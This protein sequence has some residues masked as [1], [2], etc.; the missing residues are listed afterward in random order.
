MKGA[1]CCI[2]LLFIIALYSSVMTL[3]S[4]SE[5]PSTANGGGSEILYHF[6]VFLPDNNYTFYKELKLGAQEAGREL[7]CALSFHP[8]GEEKLDF[9]MAQYSRFDGMIVYPYLEDHL[10]RKILNEINRSDVPIILVEHD[11]QDDS[12]WP[13]V[14]TNNF[15]VGRKIGELI[16]LYHKAPVEMAVVYSNKSPG[17]YA[18][19]ELVE[20]GIIAHLGDRLGAPITSRRTNLNPL[21]A[22][23]LMYH[24][25]RDEPNINTV[26]FTDSN[27]T[28]AATQV[29]ID[30][31]LVGSVQI[32]GFGTEGPILEYIEKYILLGTIAENPRQI[33]YNAVKALKELREKGHTPSY[34]DTGVQAV[35]QRNL[36][37]FRNNS[38]GQL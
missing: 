18:E 11:L 15:D 31:N 10:M 24:M 26:V 8:I 27:D 34:V 14:G 35:T 5:T 37:Q 28:L 6:A 30:M 2:G 7:G 20:M 1:A 33:G 25:L 22:E 4:L 9:F 38:G 23:Q 36:S 21:D 13:F 29:V 12:P 17:I 32:I 16:S 19:R 3:V